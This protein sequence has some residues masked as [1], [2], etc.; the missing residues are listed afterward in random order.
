MRNETKKKIRIIG[1]I[2]FIIYILLLIYFLFLSEE[3]GRK[4]FAQRDYQYNLVLFQEIRRFWIYRAAVGYLPAFLNLAGNVIGFVPFG[5]ILPVIGRRMKNGFLVTLLGFC[6]SLLVE[7]VQLV[8]KV[9][10]FDVDDLM[11][12]TLGAALGYVLFAVCDRI[13]RWIYEK[14]V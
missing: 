12:N 10:C 7:C 14:K 1:W 6:L 11:L 2:L 3:Y 8:C 4:D 13:R 5:F 9:G